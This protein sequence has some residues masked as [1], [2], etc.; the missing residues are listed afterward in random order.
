MV[1]RSPDHVRSPDHP[2]FS[3]ISVIRRVDQWQGSLFPISAMTRDD[4]DSG[5]N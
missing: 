3:W 2:I 4:G 5:M 1:F